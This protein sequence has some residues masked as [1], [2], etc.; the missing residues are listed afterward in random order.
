MA[1]AKHIGKIV[2]ALQDPAVK[3]APA[4]E[5]TSRVRADGS[6]L[7]TG[8]LGGLG[9]RVAQWLVGE[10]AR[11]LALVGRSAPSAAA[12][13]AVQAMTGSGAQVLVARADV[14][15]P[16]QLAAVL[17][18]IEQGM[19]PL[20]GVVHAAGVLDDGILL[21]QSAARF[22]A[23]L[24]PKVQGAWNLHTQTRAAPLDF[25]V[26]F[27]SAAAL[28]GAPGQGNYAAA[29]AFLDALAARRRA[30][31][32]PALSISWGPWA[33]V[34]LAARED[35]G[36]RLAGRG[37]GSLTPQQ[38]LAALGYVL[39][40]SASQV[41]VM[42]VDW[43]RT[44][45]I[46]PAAAQWPLL[47]KLMRD[48]N[49]AGDGA[50]PQAGDRDLRERLLAAP[51]GRPRQSLMESYLKEQIAHVLRLS[52]ARIDP[53]QPLDTLG[54][55]SLMALE[56]KNRLERSLGGAL[57]VTIVWNYP[58]VAAL[59]PYLLGEMGIPAEAASGPDRNGASIAAEE[60]SEEIAALLEDLEQLSEDEVR[61]LLAGELG[62]Q[63]GY[64]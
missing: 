59:A 62:G 44:R 5:C 50:K 46:Y 58:T 61:R 40:R 38:G 31:Q 35:R 28:L 6:Y 64:P 16:D 9:L 51:A 19:P 13:T 10:G 36:G 37:I 32:L 25:F 63:G 39:G 54:L 3:I 15:D 30:E 27:S 8:G 21:H 48:Q 2:V 17:A 14:A 55:D 41:V 57:S 4:P 23:V 7:I 33:E 18:Q 29:N 53:H 49:F 45:E 56:L 12:Q 42:N 60:E 43:S 34:G 11:H 52:P 20:R 24:A 1:Q 22:R 47:A 26:L